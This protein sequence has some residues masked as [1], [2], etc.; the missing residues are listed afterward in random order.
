MWR[1]F[2]GAFWALMTPVLLFGGM[3]TGYFTPTKSAAVAVVYALAVGLFYKDFRLRDLPRIML[4]TVET[5]GVVMA[6]VMASELLAYCLSVSRMPQELGAVW[7]SS[8]T[9]GWSTC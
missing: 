8:P 7:R 4:D 6:L 2:A 9:R 1:A 3:L 5:T